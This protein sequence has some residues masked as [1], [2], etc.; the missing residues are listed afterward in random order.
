MAH[1]IVRAV[2]TDYPNKPYTYELP[3]DLISE[4]VA[5]PLASR[6]EWLRSYTVW[7]P[8]RESDE[9]D[10]ATPAYVALMEKQAVDNHYRNRYVIDKE[11]K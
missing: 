2:S 7:I 6:D 1:L 11:S 5:V 3:A 10:L 4:F 8:S 9:Y